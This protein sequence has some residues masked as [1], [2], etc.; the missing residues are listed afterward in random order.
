MGITLLLYKT[1]IGLFMIG[2]MDNKRCRQLK[3]QVAA[4]SQFNAETIFR[5]LLNTAQFELQLKDVRIFII[6]STGCQ[7]QFSVM[8]Y[9]ASFLLKTNVNLK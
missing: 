2:A 9:T 8:K 1:T 7:S 5:L 6:N 4:D 3:D